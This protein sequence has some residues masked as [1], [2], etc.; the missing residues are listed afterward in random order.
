M[1]AGT[2]PAAVAWLNRETTKILS[3][4]DA[5]GRFVNQGA[6]VPLGSAE[7][8]ATFIKAESDRYGDVIKRAG[9]KLQ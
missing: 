4:P 2:P 5:R 7:W 8:F 6:A 9:I 1:P 3:A